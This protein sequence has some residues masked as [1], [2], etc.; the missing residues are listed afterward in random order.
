[1][2]HH[3]DQL[4]GI[5]SHRLIIFVRREENIDE[6][7]DLRDGDSDIVFDEICEMIDGLQLLR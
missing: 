3:Q 7:F 1:M 6:C 4:V 2:V 5:L